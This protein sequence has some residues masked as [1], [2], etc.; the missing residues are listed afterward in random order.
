LVCYRLQDTAALRAGSEPTTGAMIMYAK[1]PIMKFSMFEIEQLITR[2]EAGEIIG[3]LKGS[4][5]L[6]I[7]KIA[8][9]LG[10]KTRMQ[11]QNEET[12]THQIVFV[13][14]P[15]ETLRR[16]HELQPLD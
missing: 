1:K 10:R 8:K 6:E 12:D 9:S 14:T 16:L 7:Q 5:A 11:V 15:N 3:G 4:E 2:A 13:E